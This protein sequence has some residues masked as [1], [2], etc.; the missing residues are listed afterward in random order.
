M[1]GHLA[2]RQHHEPGDHAAHGVHEGQR[3]STLGQAPAGPEE[4]TR[5][6]GAPMAI[7]RM[8]RGRDALAYPASAW[9]TLR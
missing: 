1:H 2:Q 5:A 7:I 3:R 9:S 8:R 4:Q 6:D